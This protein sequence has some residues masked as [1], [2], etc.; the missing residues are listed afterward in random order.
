MLRQFRLKGS[1]LEAIRQKAEAQYGAGARIV[2]AEK[3]TNPG[4]VGHFCCEAL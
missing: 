4:I 3:V 2:A 1:S